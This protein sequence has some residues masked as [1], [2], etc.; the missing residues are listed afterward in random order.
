L[1][2]LKGQCHEINCFKFATSV[3][4]TGVKF[5]AGVNY[6]DANLPP[7]LKTPVENFSTDTAG[8]LDVGGRFATGVNDTGTKFA[9]DVN[10]TGGKLPPVSRTSAANLPLSPMVYSVVWGKLIYEKKPEVENLVALPFKLGSY[11]H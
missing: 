4:N 9:A 8:I 7:V 6:I 1:E 10:D 2:I 3:N 11:M 5:A